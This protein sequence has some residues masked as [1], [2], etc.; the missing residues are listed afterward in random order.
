LPYNHIPSKYRQFES[1]KNTLNRR[2]FSGA[3]HLITWHEWGKQSLQT[4]YGI[5]ASKIHVVPPGIDL[6][7]WDFAR[8]PNA[9]RVKLL[10]V[11][12]DFRRKGGEILLASYARDL[13]DRCTLDI[14]TKEDVDIRGLRGVTVHRGFGPNATDLLRLYAGADIFVFPTFADTLPLVI[15]EAMASSLPVIATTVGAL[16]EQIEDGVTGLLVPVA[17]VDALS[18]AVLR[19]VDN[20]ELRQRMGAEARRVAFERFNAAKNYP[21]IVD[22]CKQSVDDAAAASRGWSGGA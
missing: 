8:Q 19:L 21:R 2:T 7:R 11:G 14:V 22:L 20:A 15:M 9:G 1:L 12:G 4:D 6:A 5:A 16:R 10:F 17:D 13:M 3:R 18:R